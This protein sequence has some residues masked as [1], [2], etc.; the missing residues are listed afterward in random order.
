MVAGRGDATVIGGHQRHTAA[1]RLGLTP[2]PVIWFDLSS[3]Q[4]RL[5]GL[6]LD[7]LAWEEFV[8]AWARTLLAGVKGTMYV[9]MSRK[10]LPTVSRVLAE[11]GGNWSDTII[12]PKGCFVL[13][14]ADYQRQYEPL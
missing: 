2:V 9:C 13:G 7:P 1:R 14:R 3:E 10:R 11:E 8:H 4:N 12:W 6:A 5:F